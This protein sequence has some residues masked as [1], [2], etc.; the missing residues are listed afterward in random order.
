MKFLVLGCNGM[1]GHTIS[2]YLHEQGHDLIGFARNRSPFISTIVGDARDGNIV[3]RTMV[4]G[5]YDA[6]INCIGI[7]NDF[8][9]KD[10]EAAAYLNAY[11]PHFLAK[12]AQ[13]RRTIVVHIS[14]DCVFSGMRGGYTEQDLPDGKTFYD[15]SKFLGEIVNSK[16]IT[17]RCSIIGPDLSSRG[18]G[19][20][21][22]FLQ[23]RSVV[24]GYV[25]AIWTGQTTLQ[26][27]KSI[28]EAVRVKAAGLYH[29]VPAQSISKYDLLCLLNRHLRKQEIDVERD[30]SIKVDKSLRR[31]NFEML[32]YIVPDYELQI[33]DLGAWMRAHRNLYP[34]YAL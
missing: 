1:V 2:L 12:L 10:H 5:D 7:L 4:D 15:R 26:L 20:M 24:R 14:T 32:D 18:I 8:A 9:E 23:Q 28:E 13:G 6:V 11:F 34:H 30:E 33:K 27:A 29:M 21:N 3:R 17:F 31:T 19:L 22:W 16:D 25:N